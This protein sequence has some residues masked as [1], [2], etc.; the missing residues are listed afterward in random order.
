A[1]QGTPLAHRR[2]LREGTLAG[3]AAPLVAWAHL[4][5]GRT[6]WR[7]TDFDEAAKAMSSVPA[8]ART[9]DTKLLAALAMGLRGGPRD[10]IEMMVRSP[11]GMN[12]LGQRAALDAL[13]AEKG[14]L[15]GAAAFDAA[16][17]MEIAAPERAD[18]LFFK[19]L[20][21]HYHA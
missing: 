12:A 17:L 19:S 5:L 16:Y 13:T 6:Y 15:S 8:A 3:D 1:V 9:A 20:A 21:K 2:A 4:A 14:P 7:A 11:L 18:G 10:A